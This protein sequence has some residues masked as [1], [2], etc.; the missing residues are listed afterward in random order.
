MRRIEEGQSPPQ[1]KGWGRSLRASGCVGES[2]YD[3]LV[4]AVVFFGGLYGEP[5]VELF[6]DAQ[7]ERA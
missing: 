3:G 2:A 6:A 7:V 5:A 1:G 4:E